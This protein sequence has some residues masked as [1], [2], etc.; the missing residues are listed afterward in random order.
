MMKNRLRLLP[1]SQERAF[2][3]VYETA[4]LLVTE[5]LAREIVDFVSA[6]RDV[7]AG[8][9]AE[10][11]SEGGEL[12]VEPALL[13]LVC[14][15]LNEKRKAQNK[16]AFDRELLSCSKESIIADFYHKSVAD[17]PPRV[18]RFIQEELITDRGFRKPCYV[19][20][21]YT[22]HGVTDHQLRLL[23][24]RRLLRM[25]PYRG[26]ERV[27][28]THDL[29][30]G[31][32]R[33]YRDRERTRRQ[34]KR[35]A[36]FA[37][38][39]VVLA[40]SLFGVWYVVSEGETDELLRI[41]AEWNAAQAQKQGQQ[42]GSNAAKA[43]LQRFNAES[44]A[45]Q[46]N[47]SKKT[48][49]ESAAEAD[50]ERKVALAANTATKALSVQQPDLALLLAAESTRNA[51]AA[52]GLSSLLT[53]LQSY[54][55][56]RFFIRDHTNPVIGLAFNGDNLI[57]ADTGGTVLT[58]SNEGAQIGRSVVDSPGLPVL[59]SP[60]GA[61]LASAGPNRIQIWTAGG[62]KVQEI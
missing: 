53:V 2:E 20:D 3:A 10:S 58:H 25:E 37:A 9:T 51:D 14:H 18:R 56:L 48:A 32:V 34:R 55:N 47:Q 6:T 62:R 39:A 43:D 61:L 35:V 41:Q 29:L 33:E 7:A 59:M 22:R 12:N 1:M 4:P 23:V 42:A 54:A 5:N 49:L 57:S 8:P 11:V 13:S 26:T 38:L 30:T 46:A 16:T 44:L 24:D 17:M 36:A 21:A 40:L 27:E 50:H 52:V 28:L 15:G 60:D 19:D 31:V 45:A